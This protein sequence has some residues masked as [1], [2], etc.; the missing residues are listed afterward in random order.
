M[1]A[2]EGAGGG[3]EAEAADTTM[4]TLDQVMPPS[5]KRATVTEAPL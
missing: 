5:E 2:A 1:E 3:Y 4:E